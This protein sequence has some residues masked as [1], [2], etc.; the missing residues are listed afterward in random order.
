[1][2][3]FAS[4]R[5][6]TRCS[7]D[8]SSDVC[9]SDLELID[10]AVACLCCAMKAPDQAAQ[11]DHL[12]LPRRLFLLALESN[13]LHRVEVH[14]EERVIDRG[15]QITLIPALG[16]KQF[17]QPDQQADVEDIETDVS[18]DCHRLHQ[19]PLRSSRSS[20]AAT[21]S[22]IRYIHG[23]GV[24]FNQGMWKRCFHLAFVWLPRPLGESILSHSCVPDVRTSSSVALFRVATS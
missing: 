20:A 12:C 2:F 5:R 10:G 8:W 1:M 3:F 16:T 18:P 17:V 21:V 9:S 19:H 7:R 22:S 23:P 11:E 6:H 24:C 4:R 14:G 15:G 13:Q